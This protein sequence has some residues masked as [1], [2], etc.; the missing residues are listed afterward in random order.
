MRT[1]PH[2]L[3]RWTLAAGIA[4]VAALLV[5][6]SSCGHEEDPCAP[7]PPGPSAIQYDWVPAPGAMT[8]AIL[9]TVRI[10]LQRR[11]GEPAEATFFV[12]GDSVYVGEHFRWRVIQ[13]GGIGIEARMHPPLPQDTVSWSVTVEESGLDSLV[14]VT[15]VVVGRGDVIGSI[16][17]GWERPDDG[18]D[19]I[20]HYIVYYATGAITEA[21]AGGCDSVVVGHDPRVVV[22]RRLITGLDERTEYHVRVR[23]VD[24]LGRRAVLSPEEVS[25]STGHYGLSGRVIRL[26][27]SGGGAEGFPGALVKLHDRQTLTDED[28]AYRL[29]LIPDVL[30]DRLEIHPID[31][32]ER[33]AFYWLRSDTLE[34]VDQDFDA[35]LFR[36]G[37]VAL[38]S[39]QEDVC[40]RLEFLYIMTGRYEDSRYVP[41]IEKWEHFPIPVRVDPYVVDPGGSDAGQSLAEAI[42]I[43][44]HETQEE[45]FTPVLGPLD[46]G[47]DYAII[48][49]QT[50]GGGL[51]GDVSMIDPP[52]P[53]CLF[54]C[55][56]RKVLISLS[57]QNTPWVMLAVS[58]HELGH[59]LWMTHSPNP[60]HVMSAGVSQLSTTIP[61]PDEVWVARVLRYLPNGTNLGWYSEPEVW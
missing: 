23:L 25:L 34:T 12:D 26:R 6:L 31:P 52:E 57:S 40:S 41:P 5:S 15:Q 32:A 11:D 2:S 61:Q 48:V 42:E 4:S 44:N 3:L 10:D 17:V 16:G 29:D 18:K 19:A 47:A 60:Q 8:V 21:G 13:H 59:V 35:L 28:G 30:Q 39:L 1:V 33:K 20:D 43:W 58:V 14:G 27:E 24:V 55:V 50:T 54:R 7:A 53:G 46:Y 37:T 36:V 45:L 51:L 9:D 38:D 49:G 22:Q 56:P